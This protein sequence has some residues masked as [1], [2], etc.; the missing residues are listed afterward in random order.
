[1][2]DEVG[3]FIPVGMAADILGNVKAVTAAMGQLTDITSG[4]IQSD[5]SAQ[6]SGSAAYSPAA[7]AIRQTVVV[8]LIPTFYSYKKS[9]GAALVRDLNRQLGGLALT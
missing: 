1:M 3:K 2:Q 4:S 9:D 8:Q 6:L 7:A 5:I